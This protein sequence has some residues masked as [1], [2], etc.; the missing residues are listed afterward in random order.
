MT[1]HGADLLIRAAAV[2]TLVS[3]Q[4]PQRSLAVRGD[5]IAA[6]SPDPNGLDACAI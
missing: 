2:H 1:D 3:N 4:P 5:R 6:L